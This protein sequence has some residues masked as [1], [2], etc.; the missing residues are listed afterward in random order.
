MRKLRACSTCGV[1]GIGP[2][3]SV[4]GLRVICAS[5]ETEKKLGNPGGRGY[6]KRFRLRSFP[7]LSSDGEACCTGVAGLENTITEGGLGTWDFSCVLCGFAFLTLLQTWAPQ[8]TSLTI[9]TCGPRD[10]TTCA[11]NASQMG[12]A[13]KHGRLGLSFSLQTKDLETLRPGQSTG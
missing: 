12:C 4:K 11:L 8:Q 5:F 1:G 13:P 2:Y 3:G 6:E 7:G 10:P 9:L